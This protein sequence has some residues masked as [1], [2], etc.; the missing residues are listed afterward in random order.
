MFMDDCK[1]TTMFRAITFS[2]SAPYMHC[3]MPYPKPITTATWPDGIIV[4]TR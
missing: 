3:R 1:D 2:T 4:I